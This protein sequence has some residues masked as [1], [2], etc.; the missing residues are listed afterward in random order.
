[1]GSVAGVDICRR[2]K[3]TCRDTNACRYT[4]YAVFVRETRSAKWSVAT[5]SAFIVGPI[6][7]VVNIHFNPERF[8]EYY[9]FLKKVHY[10]T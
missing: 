9:F 8:P 4:D 1:V 3:S 7:T 5:S 6:K 10:F 2:E